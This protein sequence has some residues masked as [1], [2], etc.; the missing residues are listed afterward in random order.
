[1]RKVALVLAALAVTVSMSSASADSSTEVAAV[2]LVEELAVVM[3]ANLRDCDKMGVALEKFME[4]HA[5]EI[6]KLR[7]EEKKMT[8]EQKKALAAKYASRLQAAAAKILAGAQACGT[9]AR[10]KEA[11]GRF[12]P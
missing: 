3:D 2:R 4:S 8:D 5:A 1:M 10:V 9:N 7:E 11:L 12:K 6:A